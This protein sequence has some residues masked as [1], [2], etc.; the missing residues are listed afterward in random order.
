M[1]CILTF[2]WDIECQMSLRWWKKLFQDSAQIGKS[3][4]YFLQRRPTWN[5]IIS[6]LPTNRASVAKKITKSL[7]APG[8]SSALYSW[9][10]LHLH[11]KWSLYDYTYIFLQW[12]W[13]ING[14]VTTFVVKWNYDRLCLFAIH[15]F[16]PKGSKTLQP[17]GPLYFGKRLIITTNE[18]FRS[19]Y[20][21][22]ENPRQGS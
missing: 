9:K 5:T 18:F 8:I 11:H 2:L 19:H 21:V 6:Y 14:T 1:D 12:C 13:I 16:K 7:S 4:R 17:E 15:S 3:W 10:H 22:E 20:I